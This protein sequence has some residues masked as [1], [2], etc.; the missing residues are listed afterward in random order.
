L[1]LAAAVP[2]SAQMSG[3]PIPIP[4]KELKTLL[5]V[6]DHLTDTT[7]KSLRYAYTKYKAILEA[8]QLYDRINLE[9]RWPEQYQKVTV[10]EIRQ[11]F[12]SKSVWHA[13]YIPCFQNIS[14][15]EEM[16]EWLEDTGND[17]DDNLWG[18]KKTAYQFSDLREWLEERKKG[19]GK[20]KEK[21]KKGEM[22]SKKKQVV[23]ERK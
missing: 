7:N 23:K 8:V 9:G 19:K 20:Q 12:V 5:E 2:H 13:Q 14:K 4:K 16:V 22:V 18:Y 1:T 6:N 15:H 21:K 17:D 10:T 11:I 3:Q